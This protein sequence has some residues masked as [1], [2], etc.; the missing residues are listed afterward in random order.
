[1]SEI[2]IDPGN[3]CGSWHSIFLWNVFIP[4]NV[5]P[6]KLARC[7]LYG[8]SRGKILKKFFW[9]RKHQGFDTI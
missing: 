1:M 7:G 5:S 4:Q 8:D 6:A 9:V 3:S 2:L